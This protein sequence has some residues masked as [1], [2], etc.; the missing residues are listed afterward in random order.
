MRRKMR[1]MEDKMMA[2]DHKMTHIKRQVKDQQK[3][4]NEEQELL[5][6][7]RNELVRVQ[8][9]L[10]AVQQERIRVR[11][12]ICAEIELERI[13]NAFPVK[14]FFGTFTAATDEKMGL[15]PEFGAVP[16]TEELASIFKQ[17]LNDKARLINSIEPLVQHM[18]GKFYI[19]ASKRK[20]RNELK[21]LHKQLVKD[22]RNL[23]KALQ[24]LV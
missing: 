19:R 17:K 10:T 4:L 20:Q 15:T 5:S 18:S 22:V 11:E 1:F 13:D 6:V 8:H 3:L 7:K 16:S 9:V 2:N 24:M 12:S 14:D 21:S 23:T